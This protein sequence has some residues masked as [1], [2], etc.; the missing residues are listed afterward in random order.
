MF[1]YDFVGQYIPLIDIVDSST[2]IKTT[3]TV[4][5]LNVAEEDITELKTGMVTFQFIVR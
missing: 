3:I 4:E 5:A 2:P 1:F